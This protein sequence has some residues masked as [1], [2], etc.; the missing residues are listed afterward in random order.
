MKYYDGNSFGL[1]STLDK[2][3]CSVGFM[4]IYFRIMTYLY[5]HEVEQYQMYMKK[6]LSK[7]VIG[8]AEVNNSFVAISFPKSEEEGKEGEL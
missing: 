2:K 8:V 7:G 1:F 6:L 4:L 3:E 5:N